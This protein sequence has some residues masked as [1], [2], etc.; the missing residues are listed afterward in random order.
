[1]MKHIFTSLLLGVILLVGVPSMVSAGK[2]TV[3][4]TKDGAWSFNSQPNAVYYNGKTYFAWINSNK[5]LVA[6][7]YNHTTGET[8]EQIVSTG[9]SDDF[10]SPGI[11]VRGAGQ[12]LLFASKN[13]K[14]DA[15]YCWRSTNVEDITE[16]S[17]SQKL[18]GYGISSTI[19]LLLGDDL[20]VFWRSKNNIGYSLFNKVND[21]T[22]VLP[23]PATRAGFIGSDI[24][25]TYAHREE[26]PYMRTCQ[27]AD[28]TLHM[29]VTH[30]GTGLTYTNSV[31]HYLKINKNA[32]G[33]GLEFKKADGTGL[34][35]MN[36]TESKGSALDTI[37]NGRN[38]E[39]VWAYD[40]A[41]DTNNNPV[42]LYDAFT[43]AE[44]GSTT[45]H[46]YYSARWNGKEWKSTVIAQVEDGLPM[47]EYKAVQGYTFKAKSYQAGGICFGPN[48]LNTVYLSKKV[49]G[50]TFEIYRYETTDNGVTWVEKEAVTSGTPTGQVNIRPIA[51][52]GAPANYPMDIFWMQGTYENPTKYNTSISCA[53]EG[54]ETTGI[55]FEQE[56]YEFVVNETA[57]L[58][59]KLAPLFALNKEY[60]LSSSN[61]NVIE[62]TTVGKLSCKTV[63]EATI[64]ATLK[65]NPSVK[66]TCQVSV[67]PQSSFT[68]FSERII[69]DI[70]ADKISTVEQL[71]KNVASHLE[72]LSENGSYPDIDYASTDRTDWAPLKHIDRL[73]AMGLAY[74]HTN[75]KYYAN[76]N[77]KAKMDLMLTYWHNHKPSS[78]N[79]Y[80]NE[81]GEPQRM[82]QYLILVQNLGKDKVP[83]DLF[84]K[85][86][87]RL[88]DKG[89]NPGAQ[90]GANRVDVAL[91]W[92]YRGCLTEDKDLL[93]ESMDYIYSTIEYTTGAEGIQH[94]NSFTQHGRQLHIGSYGDVFLAGITK[95]CNYAAGTRYAI[96]GEQLA[97]LSRLVKDT[98][99]STIRGEYMSYNV[100]GRASTRPGATRKSGGTAIIERM[101]ALD[102][103]HVTE[104]D[105]AI[106]RINGTEYPNYGLDPKST[107][108]FRSDYT[109]HQRPAYTADL[110]LVSTRT[111]RNEYLKDN[112]EGL[113]QYFMSDGST[114][115]LVK[116]NEY[117]NIF[118]V[119]NYAKVPGVTCPE[120]K[121]IPQASTYIKMG[122]SGFVGGVTDSLYSVSAYKY[123][124]TDTQ[125]GV[126]T[127]ANK[128]W[129]F[130]DKEIVC[131]GNNIKSSSDFQVNTTVNQCVLDGE[132]IISTN[133]NESI[134]KAGDYNYENNL[135]W[136]LH[137]NVGYYFPNKGHLQL[138][139][140]ERTGSWY[141]INTNYADEEVKNNVFTLSF[142]HGVQ[143]TDEEYEYIIVP[144]ISTK[145][146]AK[147]YKTDHI[148][149]IVN[150]DSIQAVYHKELKI[151][152]L[153]FYKAAGFKKHGLTVEADAGCVVLVKDADKAETVVYVSDP[154]NGSNAINLGIETP[155]VKGRR[156]VTYQGIAPYQGRSMKFVV[157]SNTQASSGRD[158]LTDRAKWTIT[159][160]L[161][162]PAD[163]TPEV[164]GDKP[165]Y[166]IDNSTI[167]SFLFVKPGKTFSGINAPTD[168]VPSFTIDM[169]TP[170][171]MEF[172]I[173]RHRDYQNVL[174]YLRAKSVSLS[175]KN[176]EADEFTPILENISLQTSATENKIQLPK[177]V[178]YRYIR[179]AIT[180]FDKTQGS[181]IQVSDFNIGKKALLDIPETGN[182]TSI[183]EIKTVGN[184]FA[185]SAY[186]NP[187]KQGEQVQINF[188]GNVQN[189]EFKLYDVTG[190]VCDKGTVPVINTSNL[191]QGVYILHVQ[192]KVTHSN[193]STK[194]IVQ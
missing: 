147:A 159:T 15:F 145:E 154:T 34:S 41:F 105:K 91:H 45:G 50:G 5:A 93:R 106:K 111:A 19:P 100:I 143:P 120:F 173:Y 77:L 24:G 101:K 65:N 127:S 141:D 179:V 46:T 25:N 3:P 165:E 54:V 20:A 144:G 26:V 114:G 163:Q 119:W 158:I 42:V 99:L 79:W 18:D 188:T 95:A 107:H 43:A 116:G 192:D 92:M 78:N 63:G 167:S 88:K 2:V 194:I 126:N 21:A 60:T 37:A 67:L 84:T 132:V 121:E 30:L 27:G 150:S 64:T 28:G 104:Y 48:S 129:F 133:G 14:E 49:S 157:N 90:T 134:L 172:F 7:S 70:R 135:N 122:Q 58:K 23:T 151:Y 52:K 142:N 73:L 62:I 176:S 125:F 81:I 22:G 117:Y 17:G 96:A 136:A 32:T 177:K 29:V 74:T 10:S 152:G 13:Q 57:E 168:Y 182:P 131:L 130:F 160:S 53:G 115:I 193:A 184:E 98:Y 189:V 76:D 112:G 137:G 6:A 148:E 35:G 47:S 138:S 94:D 89:G 55:F 72:Q 75:S 86:I 69:T 39:K 97:I 103:A 183:I 80:Q 110:R 16:W 31:I 175:G 38:T 87:T 178:S 161:E 61:P 123:T 153:V 4:L 66:T 44:D 113:K 1:M 190:K 155:A 56:A 191:S 170:Q 128:A 68:T 146:E 33:K 149:V 9:Y 8:K 51:V 124:D 181:T 118:P 83:A 59:V 164:G 186:P 85:S 180:D 12:I 139:A 40:I 171:E 36:V 174:E 140:G 109:L 11:A 185:V 108:F 187:V 166:I 82:G 162:G 156:L 169:Q 71:D 102:P